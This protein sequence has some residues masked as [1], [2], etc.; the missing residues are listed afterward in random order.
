LRKVINIMDVKSESI[1]RT[2]DP[3][4]YATADLGGA[5]SFVAIPMLA[6]ETL[7]GA[8]TIYRQTVRPFSD[9]T[10]RHAQMFAAQSVIALENA[11]M[12]K[13]MLEVSQ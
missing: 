1:Y 5:R 4:R 7:V 8:F 2:D 10:T 3:L 13:A 9:D 11:R 6:G 12:I